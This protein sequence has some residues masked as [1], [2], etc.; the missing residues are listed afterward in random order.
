MSRRPL[1]FETLRHALSGNLVGRLVQVFALLA[2]S[3][4]LARAL[5]PEGLGIVAIVSAAVRMALV[6]AQEGANKLAERELAGAIGKSDGR[7]ARA[8]VLFNLLMSM[9]ICSLGMTALLVFLVRA[10]LGLDDM[11]G[12]RVLWAA[13]ALLMVTIVTSALRSLLRGAGQ[14][15]RAI[16]ATNLIS[17]SVPVGYLLWIWN[18]GPLTPAIALWIQVATKLTFLPFLLALVHRYWRLVPP[19]GTSD[20]SLA[21]PS[22]WYWASAQFT[23]L[24]IV[25]VALI[26]IGTLSLSLLS[27]PEQAGLFRI[28]GRVFLVAGFVTH[29][30]QSAYGPRISFAYQSGKA[31]ALEAPSRML[32]AL[33]L[34]GSLTFLS[35]FAIFGRS[36][37]ILVFGPPFEAAFVPAMIMSM[38]AISV[39]LSAVSPKLLKMTGEQRIVL[40]GALAGLGVALVV[41]IFLVPEHGATGGAIAMMAAVSVSRVIF[42][43]GVRRHLGF[44]PLPNLS[45]LRLL[46]SKLRPG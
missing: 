24:G 28:G 41:A 26:E 8:A 11:Q 35:F 30:V 45:S 43:M 21:I 23:A 22:E 38:A 40:A 7:Q 1:S 10:P 33:A 20:N 15:V 37:L 27:T 32:S 4:V 42:S 31:D 5:G 44:E 17:A 18:A 14:T 36:V 2:A 34:L 29:A 39:S 3:V 16:H 13:L 25:A 19:R 12:A 6:P 9:L 46:V